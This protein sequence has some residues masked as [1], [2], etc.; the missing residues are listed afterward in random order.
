MTLKIISMFDKLLKKF[1]SDFLN[2]FTRTRIEGENSA[3]YSKTRRRRDKWW[4]DLNHTYILLLS[5]G[6]TR[7]YLTL[8]DFSW[9]NVGIASLLVMS[10]AYGRIILIRVVQLE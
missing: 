1:G 3:G 4:I 6:L 9:K 5:S 10:W 8:R 2:T 7:I